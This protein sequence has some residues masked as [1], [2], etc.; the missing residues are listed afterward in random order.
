MAGLKLV[1]LSALAMVAFAANSLLCRMALVE[2]QIDPASFTLWRILSGAII[3][4]LIVMARK[5]NPFKAGSLKSGLALMVYAGGFSFAYISMTT[6]AGALLL[7]GAVQITMIGWGLYKGERMSK[8]QWLGFVLAIVGLV[9]L[10]LPSASVPEISSAALMV[11]AGIAWGIY[12]LL[13]KGTAMPIEATAGNFIRALPFAILLFI[14][15]LPHQETDYTGIAYAIASGAIASGLGYAL[16]YSILPY[17]AAIKAATLQLSVPVIAVFAG[18]M[19]LQEAFTTRIVIS[20]A[21]VLGGVG[22]VIWVKSTA[23]QP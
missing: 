12:S 13:G 20:S 4:S 14:L 18:W 8:L 9:L 19:F 16:W 3:L 15:F 5:R 10:L 21:L 23:H 1:M 22:L 2:T 17:I 6:G 7:F 11:S